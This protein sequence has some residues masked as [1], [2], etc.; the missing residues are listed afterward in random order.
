MMQV[1]SVAF[2]L[3]ASEAAFPTHQNSLL[4]DAM[5]VRLKVPVP[6]ATMLH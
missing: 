3:T 6:G 1:N 5:E 2:I 4:P